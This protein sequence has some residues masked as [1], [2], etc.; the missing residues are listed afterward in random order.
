VHKNMKTT[1]LHAR[2]L[3]YLLVDGFSVF[4][5]GEDKKPLIEWTKYQ[6]QLPT[7]E[8]INNW[9]TQ[10]PNANIGIAVGKISGIV[11]V[12]VD[13]YKGGSV[14]PFPKT[15]TVK[16]GSGGIQLYYKYLSG[17]R[18]SVNKYP[19]YPNVDIRGEGGYVVAP[20]SKIIP[21]VSTANGIY[22]I[23]DARPFEPFPIE[24]FPKTIERKGSKF[25]LNVT[26][27]SRNNDMASVIGTIL[28]PL[29]ANKFETDG[30]QAALA[31]N[32]TYKPPLPLPEL[33]ATFESIAKKELARR[34]QP[35]AKLSPIQLSEDEIIK[36]TAKLRVNSNN[37]PYKDMKNAYLVISQHPQTKDKLRYNTFTQEIEYNGTV[38]EETDLVDFVML[39][40]EKALPNISKD[41]VYSAIQHYAYQNKYDEAQD[42]LKSLRWDGTERLKHWLTASTSVKDDE[43]H[44]GVGCEWFMGIINRI[45]RPG[46]VFDYVLMTVG[47]QGIGK[48]SLFRILG[49]KWYKSFTG[50]FDNKDFY[51]LLRGAI[52]ID[53]DEGATLYKTESIKIKS[54]IT[55]TQDEYRA[56]YDRLNKKYP[57]RF[58]FS[59][60]TNNTEPFQ[61]HTGNRRYWVVDLQETINFK[62]LEENRDQMFA[63]GYYHFLNKTELPKVPMAIAAE[64]QEDHMPRD[65]W[66]N[67]IADYVFSKVDYLKGSDHFSITNKDIFIDVLKGEGLH[68]MDRRT[69]TRIGNILT[70]KYF[71]MERKR[72]QDYGL[73]KYKYF[74][75]EERKAELRAEKKEPTVS[76]EEEAFNKF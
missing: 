22:E 63:E 76:I 8:E 36:K 30:W 57:R 39:L 74:I 70:H 40:Q 65:E 5:V 47:K 58:V 60:S 25:K 11:V 62:W 45:M 29:K 51:I 6:T 56:P 3:Q 64:R 38:F 59:M 31:I 46:C 12:D 20:P 23:I 61:D 68:K 9:W 17:V 14:D 4:P 50:T 72:I 71:G 52:I 44:Q 18:N 1:T 19:Q 41:A 13:V 49:G 32:A 54:I 15:Y 43:Y 28:L 26:S 37:I 2:A 35:E 27:G 7:E 10:F 75:T 66:A 48:T 33:K 55:Q 67:D 42:W 24:M 21:K 53:L 69:E 16:T 34:E 73:R